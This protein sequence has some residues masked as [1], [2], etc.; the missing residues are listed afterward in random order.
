MNRLDGKVA[1]ISGG[2]R[3]QG[4]EIAVKFA[5]EG[6]DVIIFDLCHDLDT[7]AY[8][9]GTKDDLAETAQLVEAQGRRC[10]SAVAD[11]RDQAEIDAVVRDGI[12]TFGHIDIAICNAGIVDFAPLW[13]ITE[14][15]WSDQVDIN[16]SGV[17]RTA[18]AV[19]P[20]M[21]ERLTG[22]MVFTSSNNGVE[23]GQNYAHYIAAKHGVIGLMR[24]AALE[25]GPYNIR[26]NAVLP[27]PC[28]TIMNNN[29]V[30][31]ARIGGRPDATR[32]DYLA[33]VRNWQ[34]L[35]NRTALHPSAIANAMIWLVSDEASEVTGVE[36]PVD[37]GHLVLPGMNPSPI[38]DG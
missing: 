21:M 2:A 22:A 29:P 35:R 9:L 12:E 37:A 34:L 10:V 14:E 4:R 32:D 19:A 17:W 7:V 16:L 38:V 36:L 24:S 3:G 13:E 28:D 27:G 31:W 5:S 11:V 15:Q 33:S 20:H 26:V 1:L 30:G 6:A 8:P 25:L 18:K 23:A